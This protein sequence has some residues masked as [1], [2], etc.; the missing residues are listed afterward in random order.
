M[1][2]NIVINISPPIQYLGQN[3]LGNQTAGFLKL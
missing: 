1:K 2:T 3:S